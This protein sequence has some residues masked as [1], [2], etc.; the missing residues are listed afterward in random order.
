LND[1]QTVTV[2]SLFRGVLGL[3]VGIAL[4]GG[5][6]DLRS[7]KLFASLIGLGQTAIY[8]ALVAFMHISIPQ[9]NAYPFI[10]WGVFAFTV[11]AGTLK[12]KSVLQTI[13]LGI[14]VLFGGSFLIAGLWMFLSGFKLGLN[15]GN[16]VGGTLFML[17]GGAVLGAMIYPYFKGDSVADE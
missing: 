16:F 9:Y 4:G 12:T 17:I 11:L 5:V 7:G 1:W 13:G 10:Y 14:Y 3:A 6:R 8:A 2:L 15:I